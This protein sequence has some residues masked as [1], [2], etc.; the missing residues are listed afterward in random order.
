MSRARGAGPPIGRPPV[1]ALLAFGAWIVAGA[2]A[3]L[4]PAVQDGAIRPWTR[5]NAAA[6]AALLRAGGFAAAAPRSVLVLGGGAIDVKTG[7]SG[8]A[9]V[10]ILAAA[11][12]AFPARPWRRLV[13]LPIAAAAVFSLNLLRLA[14]LVL[15]ARYLPSRLELFHVYVWQTLIAVLSFALFLLWASWADRRDAMPARAV[16]LPAGAPGEG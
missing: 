8:I 10:L 15:V 9:A 6:A 13:G 16:P 3:H 14:T 2:A 7:C 12:L 1:R 11:I 4:L 5:A